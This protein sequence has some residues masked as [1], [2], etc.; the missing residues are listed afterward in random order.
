MA[1]AKKF[2]DNEIGTSR[3][4]FTLMQKLKLCHKYLAHFQFYFLVHFQKDSSLI[5][6]RK[7]ELFQKFM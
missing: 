5:E 4:R 3:D 6:A 2:N 7:L 1:E